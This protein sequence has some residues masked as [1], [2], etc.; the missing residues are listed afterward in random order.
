M[1]RKEVKNALVEFVPAIFHEKKASLSGS[2]L[3]AAGGAVSE[4]GS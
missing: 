1:S 3:V 2:P 4:P